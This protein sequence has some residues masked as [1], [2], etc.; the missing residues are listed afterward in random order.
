M[1]GCIYFNIFW[2]DSGLVYM[3]KIYL[4]MRYGWNFFDNYCW[5]IYIGI[6]IGW[7]DIFFKVF[8]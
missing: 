4:I 5:F 1:N 3:F 8:N 7:N 6:N 2:W